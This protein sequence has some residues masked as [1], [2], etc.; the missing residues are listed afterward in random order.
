MASSQRYD[1]LYPIARALH[2]Q[3]LDI[4]RT[5]QTIIAST[6]KVI[7]VSQ[8]CLMTFRNDNS[9]ENA[10]VVGVQDPPDLDMELWNTLLKFGLVGFVH[11]GQRTVN[12][13]DINHDARWPKLPDAKFMPEKGSAVGLPLNKGS[14]TFGVMLFVHEQIDY[15]DDEKVELLEEIAMMASD[16]IGNAIDFKEARARDSR[17]QTLFDDAI[18][19]IIL[20][21]LRGYIVDVNRKACDFLGIAR[22]DLLRTPISNIHRVDKGTIKSNSFGLLSR[23]EEFAFRSSVITASGKEI[24]VIVRARRRTLGDHDVIE[25]I[26]EDVTAQM[27]L[28][29]LRRDLSAMVYHDLRG[30]LQNIKGSVYKLGEVLANHENRAVMTL[31]HVCINSTRQLQRM[32]DSLLDIQRLEEGTIRLNRQ[33]VELRVLLSDAVQLVQPLALEAHQKLTLDV[34]DPPLMMLMDDDMILRVVINLMENAVKYSP[35]GGSIHVTSKMGDDHVRISVR[36]SGPG[37]PQNMLSRVFDKFSRVK[38]RDAPKGVGLGLAFC[39]LAVDAHGGKIWVESEEGKGSE[40]T[41]TIP[42]HIDAIEDQDDA[43][44]TDTLALA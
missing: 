6:S 16:A 11:H 25:W 42:I 19:P 2:H 34:Q 35:D 36:D 9:I 22:G 30:P 15:F 7:G 18:T 33:P 37:I 12:I 5:L 26:E 41:F 3:S 1:L 10:Y 24:P 43:Q 39:R 17:Y 44:D 13:R 27:E 28:E 8:G 21:D 40:F 23:D 14:Y 38:Y 32:V 4:Q 29:Q 20:T 31:L